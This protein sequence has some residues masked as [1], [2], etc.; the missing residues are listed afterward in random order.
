M[1]APSQAGQGEGRSG[2]ARIEVEPW[3][4]RNAVIPRLLFT[5]GEA[6]R[7]LGMSL[8]HFQ[9]HVQPELR[10][11]ARGNCG[12]IAHGIWNAGWRAPFQGWS[13]I[14]RSSRAGP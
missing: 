7:A 14:G 3:G 13:R 6:A 11:A 12:C 10:C 8:S 2:P 4:R 1:R 5:P 9:R